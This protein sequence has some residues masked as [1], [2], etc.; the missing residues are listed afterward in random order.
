VEG[1]VGTYRDSIMVV[2]GYL[3]RVQIV[4]RQ[5]VAQAQGADIVDKSRH[6]IMSKPSRHIGRKDLFWAVEL[7]ERMV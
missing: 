6:A 7:V 4:S 1:W 2:L 3:L 5:A